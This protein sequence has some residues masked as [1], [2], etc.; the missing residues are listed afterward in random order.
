MKLAGWSVA[1]LVLAGCVGQGGVEQSAGTSSA[2][3]VASP[4]TYTEETG[5]IEG[6]VT[7]DSLAPI[8]GA[9]LVLSVLGT[10]AVSDPEGRFGFSEVTPGRVVLTAAKA[11]YQSWAHA[12]D[13]LP[14]S[15]VHVAISL[16]A[17]PVD[18]PYS[19]TLHQTGLKFCDAD[20]DFQGNPY[21]GYVGT[22]AALCG[23][24]LV[25]A[26]RRPEVPSSGSAQI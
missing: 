13:V 17:A 5:A 26:C 22:F 2:P 24:V 7:D 15:R 4:A 1:F 25:R 14:G 16:V 12:V 9:E 10:A 8:A 11:G 20:V 18:E 23:E 6:V 19:L 21:P 3:N